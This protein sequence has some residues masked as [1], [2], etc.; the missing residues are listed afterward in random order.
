MSEQGKPIFLMDIDAIRS[1]EQE[2]KREFPRRLGNVTM[3]RYDKD[4]TYKEQSVN[5]DILRSVL[6]IYMK[7]PMQEVRDN[8]LSDLKNSM[9]AYL[10]IFTGAFLLTLISTISIST[11]IVRQQMKT[12]AVFYIC[13]M[14]WQDCIKINQ[15]CT[16]LT[17]VIAGI[18]FLLLTIVFW[19]LGFF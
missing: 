17:A 7:Y 13:G 2:Q 3:I 12:Y 9:K 5:D 16:L 19:A 14:Q 8:S 6:D 10:T 4:I 18:S 1:E 11:I 15:I